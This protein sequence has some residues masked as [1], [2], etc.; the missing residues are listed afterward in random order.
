MGLE[1]ADFLLSD[2]ELM[3]LNNLTQ[4]VAKRTYKSEGESVG[5]VTVTFEFGVPYLRFVY[6][7]VGGSERVCLDDINI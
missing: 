3:K 4:T 7:S 2:E 1:Q 6:V 5:D